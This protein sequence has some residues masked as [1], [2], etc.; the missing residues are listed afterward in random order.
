MG[1]LEQLTSHGQSVWIDYIRRDFTRTGQLADLV[2]RGVRG[3]TSN[4]SIFEKAIGGSAEY[5]DALQSMLDEDPDRSPT[6]LF[7]AVA[8]IDIQEAADV[9]RS[10][11][12]DSAGADGFVSLEVS[13]TLAHDAEGTIRDARRLW[14]AVDRPNLMIKVPA[15]AAGI[16][17][18]EELIAEGINVNVTLMFSMQH[19][20]DV[21]QAY[22][23][24]LRRA[25][26]P[27]RIASVASFF[28]SR[29]ESAVDKALDAVG[30]AGATQLRG[31][32]AI[33]NSKLAYQ[34]YQEIF[35]GE[36]F[37]DLAQ[38]GARS[39]RVLWASTSTKDP[40]YSD[41]MYVEE[42]VGDNTVN[43]IPPA[44]LDAFVDHGTARADAVLED[45]E[46]AAAAIAALADHGIDFDAITDQL[47]T[48]GVASFGAAFDT[49]LETIADKS[50]RLLAASIDPQTLELGDYAPAVEAT[51]ARWTDDSLVARMWDHDFSVWIDQPA[52]EITDRLGWLTLPRTMRDHLED[53]TWFVDGVRADGFTTAVLLGMGG[54]SLAPEVFRKTFGVAEG[55][56]DLL[57]L[58]T[59][60]PQAV[61]TMAGQ[62]DP[63]RTLFVVAS[64]SG[65]TIEPLSFFEFFWAQVAGEVEEPGTHFA[66]ITDPG[67]QLAALGADRGFRKIFETIPDVGGRYSALTHF[68]LVPA[69]LIGVDVELLLDQAL[70]MMEASSL[71]AGNNPGVRLGV[72][73][74][75]LATAGRDKV[76]FVTSASFASLPDWLEQLVA[77]STGKDGVGI[78]PVAGERLAASSAY[79]ADRVFVYIGLASDH[80][81]EQ[82]AALDALAAAGEPVVRIVVDQLA[83]LASEMYRF[84]VAIAAAGAMLR[85]HPF[86]QPDVQRAKVL[87]QQAMAGES[88]GEEIPEVGAED[89]VALTAAMAE[90][91]GQIGPGDFLGIQAFLDPTPETASSLQAARHTA[92]ARLG[93]ATTVGFGPRFLHS[94]GQ[95]HK[96]GANNGVF[97]QVVHHFT[98]EVAV[99]GSVFS[100]G[101]LIG[102]Q[103]DGDFRALSGAGRRVVRVCLGDDVESGLANLQAAL[104]G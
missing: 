44:T 70:R 93:V 33:A 31:V 64:K 88:P 84:E 102:A 29:V 103:A 37:A 68:G 71:P 4:P 96:G 86:N 1:P 81:T 74:G 9:L 12:D 16:P 15:T 26:D 67:S 69:A 65:T 17:A 45:V 78:I 3:V 51:I 99:P 2:G 36:G 77:E 73:L 54:S 82:L 61:L 41:V 23:R 39:Q 11:Y 14:A 47:Q 100:F 53:I 20:E 62:I 72:A 89:P 60:H 104:R 6:D 5:D 30:T 49:M 95:L 35:E 59:T 40:A 75:E 85:I 91:L 87:A 21:A 97:L 63:S 48:D 28:V 19:Y 13:P 80:D 38:R 52:P 57:V 24:G 98:P 27:T 46:A 34:R 8:V 25:A 83:D 56:L 94:A 7:E 90:F 18:I 22:L 55:Y 101:A 76:T 50:K 10:V 66:A 92:Q 79:G 32:A 58:D 43:T 42:L